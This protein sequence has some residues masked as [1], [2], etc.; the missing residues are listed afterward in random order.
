MID[1][2]NITSL[3][4]AYIEKMSFSEIM[5]ISKKEWQNLLYKKNVIIID[6]ARLSPSEFVKVSYKFGNPW[7]HEVYKLHGEKINDNGIDYW[8]DQSGLYKMPLCWHKDNSWH[9]RWQ[10]PI[11]F[12]F[13]RSIPDSHTGII[14]YLDLRY[15]FNN[16]LSKKEQDWLSEHKVLIQDYRNK[17]RQFFY[18]LVQKNPITH[19][20]SLF[21]TAMDIDYNFLGLKKHH[22]YKKGNTPLIKAIHSSGKELPLNYFVDYIKKTMKFKDCHFNKR[23]KPNMIQI[24]SNLDVVHMRTGISENPK[25]RLLWR[26]TIAHDFQTQS[27]IPTQRTFKN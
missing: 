26:K 9:P 20:K 16:V 12:L 22:S 27:N 10:C 2:T 24:V 23:W 1:F 19:E 25:K 5:S 8:D 13:S 17:K 18:P 7:T 15:V 14:H 6:K 3:F 11:R 4:G 21:L